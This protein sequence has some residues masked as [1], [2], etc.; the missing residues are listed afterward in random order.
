MSYVSSYS[1]AFFAEV[2]SDEFLRFSVKELTQDMILE[3]DLEFDI[4]GVWV[5]RVEEA[6]AA[7][8]SG[9]MVH[10]LILSINDLPVK[11]LSEFKKIM[12]EL[13]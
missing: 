13:L 10:D 12:E 9:M 3:N 6:G 5:S 1:L 11:D 2:Y 8:L 7:S 4:E